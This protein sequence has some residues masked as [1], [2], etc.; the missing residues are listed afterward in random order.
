MIEPKTHH[1]FFD[2]PSKNAVLEVV[3]F[4]DYEGKE[5]WTY[6]TYLTARN[7]NF[8]FDTPIKIVEAACSNADWHYGIT[9]CHR[10]IEESHDTPI[11]NWQK[12]IWYFKVGCDFSHYWDE[13]QCYTLDDVVNEGLKTIDELVESRV[14]VAKA[15]PQKEAL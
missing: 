7:S 13:G 3:S 5:K 12:G 2:H 4:K 11:E 15:E 8:K 6:Y 14:I 1:Y 9:Y 10:I